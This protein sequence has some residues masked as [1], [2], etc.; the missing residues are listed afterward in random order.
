MAALR[1][2]TCY[3][4][5]NVFEVPYGTGVPG[6]CMECPK[7]VEAMCIA[8]LDTGVSTSPRSIHHHREVF[9]LERA[10]WGW[11]GRKVGRR[12]GADEFW[13]KV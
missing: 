13:S 10:H 2:F 7:C 3:D 4:C 5:G 8:P 6:R 11:A 9:A 1:K 12:A